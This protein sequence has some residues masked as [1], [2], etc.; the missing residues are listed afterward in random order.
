[1][2]DFNIAEIAVTHTFY[3]EPSNYL[4][5][6][7]ENGILPTED[8]FCN[9]ILPEIDEDFPNCRHHPYEVTYTQQ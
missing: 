5:Y 7:Q 1:M 6:C 9:F 3:Y 8:G 4:E 2:T